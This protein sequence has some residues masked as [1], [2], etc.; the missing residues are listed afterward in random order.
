M[1]FRQITRYFPLL[2]EVTLEIKEFTE[3]EPLVDLAGATKLLSTFFSIGFLE[4]RKLL[5]FLSLTLFDC[6][7]M[8]HQ[9]LFTPDKQLVAI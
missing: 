5:P 4:V 2:Y 1:L 9:F 7:K 6:E 3:P 8:Y